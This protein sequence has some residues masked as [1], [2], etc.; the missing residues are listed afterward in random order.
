MPDR[1]PTADTSDPRSLLNSIR[2]WRIAA[3]LMVLGPVALPAHASP[4]VLHYDAAWGGALAGEVILSLDDDSGQFRN[5]IEIRSV[6]IARWLT[7]FRAHAE[8]TGVWDHDRPTPARYEAVYDLRKRRDKQLQVRFQRL[9]PAFVADTSIP[10]LP[11]RTRLAEALRRDVVDP[12][13][14]LT[15]VRAMAREG[16]LNPGDRHVV[17]VFDGK[18]RFD[19]EVIVGDRETITAAD[20]PIDALNLSLRLHPV[21]LIKTERDDQDDVER[22]AE[23]WVTA[24]ERALPLRLVLDI[25]Y[26]PLVISVNDECEQPGSCATIHR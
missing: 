8:S 3:V 26:A 15:S 10:I 23:L 24:D 1:R 22:E 25:A 13:S 5:S 6:G 9:G 14:A 19:V 7:S 12:L 11:E 16:R 17:H 18:R 2:A 20:A 21:T 4:Y